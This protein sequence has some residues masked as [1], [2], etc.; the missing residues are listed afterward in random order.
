MRGLARFGANVIKTCI[1]VFFEHFGEL[2]RGAGAHAISDL[3]KRKK[4][5]NGLGRCGSD[6]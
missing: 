5:A 1:F 6:P 3:H 2:A 4:N